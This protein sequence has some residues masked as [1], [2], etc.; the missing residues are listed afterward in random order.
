MTLLGLKSKINQTNGRLQVGELGKPKGIFFVEKIQSF[1]SKSSWSTT[2]WDDKDKAEA[3]GRARHSKTR[4]ERIHDGEEWDADAEAAAKAAA[5]AQAAGNL[6]ETAVQRASG[7]ESDDSKRGPFI[8]NNIININA[9]GAPA[10]GIGA[11]APSNASGAGVGIGGGAAA[12]ASVGKNGENATEL[13]G[14]PR[15][16]NG[17]KDLSSGSDA[18]DD[19]DGRKI[20]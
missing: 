5:A 17:K 7:K 9:S 16:K 20:F 19:K 1:L 13:S 14:K 11:A 15:E 12:A 18:D 6:T 8:N 4:G 10:V 3:Q 2:T